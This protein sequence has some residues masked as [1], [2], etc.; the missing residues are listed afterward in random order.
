[1]TLRYE[2]LPLPGDVDQ[3]LFIYHTDPGSSSQDN[4]ALLALL[5]GGTAAP[6][7][8]R[9]QLDSSARRTEPPEPYQGA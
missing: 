4:L 2:A 8:G 6:R 3:V 5:S 9:V 1:M 7:G